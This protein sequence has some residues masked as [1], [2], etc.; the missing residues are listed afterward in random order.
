MQWLTKIIVITMLAAS[1]GTAPASVYEQ[2]PT[3]DI[4]VSSCSTNPGGDT[5]LRAYGHDGYSVAP[6]GYPFSSTDW[7][8][9]MG[10]SYL[11]WDTSSIPTGAYNVLEARLTVTHQMY[12]SFTLEMGLASPLEARSVDAYFSESTWLYDDPQNK[13]PGVMF[14]IGDLSAY[15]ESNRFPIPINLLANDASLGRKC[16]NA[17]FNA[18]VNSPNRALGLALCSKMESGGHDAT[19]IYRFYSKE[20]TLSTVQPRLYLN[21]EPI[22]PTKIG[23]AKRAQ[24]G[25]RVYLKDVI[26]TANFTDSMHT[27]F[28]EEQDRSCGVAVKVDDP[29]EG[30]VPGEIVSIIGKVALWDSSELGI[31]GENV[32]RTDTIGEPLKPVGMTNRAVG[33]GALGNQP[34]I[35]GTSGL[36]NVG[37]LIRTTGAVTGSKEAF[38]N[39]FMPDAAIF[40]IDDGSGLVDGL[41]S[42]RGIAVL[43]TDGAIPTGNVAVTGVIRVI[44]GPNGITR[45]L[46]PLKTDSY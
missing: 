26:V 35:S 38:S 34:E 6:D 2:V 18:G 1:V 4:W 31:E 37:M 13:N 41:T 27:L 21:L 14:G 43:P 39:P 28:V 29:I 24:Y 42:T 16:F 30:L 11:K 46:I 12:P 3:D 19:T 36:N 15:Q 33:G 17:H 22:S 20:V 10:Y 9:W 44:S 25:T 5:L 32:I 45:I 40:W 8:A 23:M 7:A